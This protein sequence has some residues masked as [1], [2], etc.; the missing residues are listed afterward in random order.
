MKVLV[1]LCVLFTLFAL[2]FPVAAAWTPREEAEEPPSDSG[3][4]EPS[5]SDGLFYVETGEKEPEV[6]ELTQVTLLKN[7]EIVE[8]TL[9]DYL[10]G[11]LAAEMPASFEPEALKAQAVALRTYYIRKAQ[12]G[13][14]AH[15]QAQICADSTCCAAYRDITELR[16]KWGE[17]FEN[18]LK[19]VTAA[20]RDTDGKYLTY[21]G[22]PALA[23]FH[24]SS[25][26]YTESSGEIWSSS[27]PYLVSVES[28]ETADTV[29]GY[30]T[31]VTVSA[32]EFRETV[33]ARYPGTKLEGNPEDWFGETV[34]D[35]SGRLSTVDIGGQTVTGPALRSMFALRST[36]VKLEPGE[37]SVTMTTTGYGHGVG[38]S[39]Y[40]ANTMAAAGADYK[41]IL[42][43]Y[44]PGTVLE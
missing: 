1:I 43:H 2:I 10:I 26:G 22:Q 30:V 7:G 24:S 4:P 6:D 35:A 38:M 18:N 14:S 8:L 17:S 15:P 31:G 20:V 28:P 21:D 13:T 40:G 33:K 23:V 29:P 11:A 44:Y 5:A 12:S 42:E 25:A 32:E 41:E 9:R 39:Q 19:R 37:K 27:L 3:D 16:D 36:A 34:Y